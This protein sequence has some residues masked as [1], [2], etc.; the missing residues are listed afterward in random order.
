MSSI[1]GKPKPLRIKEK[2]RTPMYTGERGSVMYTGENEDNH[3]Q[4]DKQYKYLL[5]KNLTDQQS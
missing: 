1:Q 2:D 3:F 4:G 5:T